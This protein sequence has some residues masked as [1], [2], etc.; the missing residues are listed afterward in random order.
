MRGW[1]LG[2]LIISVLLAGLLAAQVGRATAQPA[3]RGTSAARG[4]TAAGPALPHPL[5]SDSS[6]P[7]SQHP[8]A[9]AR[10]DIASAGLYERRIQPILAKNCYGCHG[11]AKTSGL[12]LRT[13]DGMLQGGSRG[14]ILVP[15]R[16]E[17]S[18]LYRYVAG[19][20]KPS[21]P[22]TG[23]LIPEEVAVLK[24]WIAAGAPTG[25]GAGLAFPT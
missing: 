11:D 6:S 13:R 4:R 14:P 9:S 2:P 22:P 1:T 23:P 21:M 24:A 18:R 3:E 8:F 12:D 16:P 10:N 7:A 17:I 20:E 5:L 15:G 19:L 25:G